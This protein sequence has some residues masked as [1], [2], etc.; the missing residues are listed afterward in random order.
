MRGTSAEHMRPVLDFLVVLTLLPCLGLLAFAG[1]LAN[2]RLKE[3]SAAGRLAERMTDMQ[4]EAAL[5]AA[6]SVELTSAGVQ[7]LINANHITLAQ[8]NKTLGFELSVPV[9]QARAET[10]RAL[11]QA[12]STPALRQ[13]IAAARS[14]ILLARHQ[15]DIDLVEGA[16]PPSLIELFGGYFHAADLTA[17]AGTLA[18]D[19]LSAATGVG[20]G[21]TLPKDVDQLQRVFALN[22]EF[23]QQSAMAAEASGS[24]ATK[25]Q[26]V[27]DELAIHYDTYRGEAATLSAYL[28]PSLQA[29][30]HRAQKSPDLAAALRTI[31]VTVATGRGG[32]KA[33]ATGSLVYARH[34][35]PAAAAHRQ[36][37]ASAVAAGVKAAEKQRYDSRLTAFITLGLAAGIILLTGITLTVTGG[38]LR[39]RLRRLAQAARDFSAGQPKVIPVHGPREIAL[40]SEAL[41]HATVALESITEKTELLA[42]GELA[43]LA[44]AEPTPGRL[45]RAVDV[46]VERVAATMHELE[47]LQAQLRHRADHDALTGLPNRTTA[48]RLLTVA[49]SRA[50]GTGD[51]VAIL[52]IDLD[53]FKACN[54]TYGH[55]AGDHVLQVAAARMRAQLPPG[56]HVCRLGGDEFLILLET[57]TSEADVVAV[58]QR[59]TAVLAEPIQ[60][61]GIEVRIGGSAGAAVA[62]NGHPGALALIRAADSG[63]Y[64]AKEAGRGRVCLVRLAAPTVPAPR[65]AD[66]DS[67]AE[68]LS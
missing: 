61:E 14:G 52:F 51:N 15:V 5:F 16:R 43:A 25:R 32:F 54:D 3:A 67:P 41:N 18:S 37:L 10:D 12:W 26:A 45:G 59:V 39:R 58:G 4:Q 55:A 42:T 66:A 60:W 7:A 20:S 24:V 48:E 11:E 13:S 30:W 9:P 49:L 27:I 35:V 17:A 40:A 22:N 65:A 6:V 57:V 64:K 8:L 21:T 34:V 62:R 47:R 46:S 29:E 1:V 28:S 38:R 44:S 36:L 23:Q 50:R 2:N 19:Q 68:R 56:G 53:K 33:T 31:A 63:V